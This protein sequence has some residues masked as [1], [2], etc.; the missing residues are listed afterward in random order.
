M[1]PSRLDAFRQMVAKNPAN[2]LAQ[3][4]LANEAMKEGSYQEAAD[5]YAVY[6][7]T[8]DDEGNGW[9]RYAE[10]LVELGRLGDAQQALQSGISAAHR[11]GHPSMA[12]ELEARLESLT[13]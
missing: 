11:F 7:A 4:G 3:Y 10:A 8:Y 5:H 9:G 6:L 13:S 1:T 2:A 12:S